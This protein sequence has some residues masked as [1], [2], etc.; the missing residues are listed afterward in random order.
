MFVMY[1]AG[2]RKEV[3]LPK[4]IVHGAYSTLNLLNDVQQIL[5]VTGEGYQLGALPLSGTKDI[6]I[7]PDVISVVVRGGMS[8]RGSKSARIENQVLRPASMRKFTWV[9]ITNDTTPRFGQIMVRAT[10]LF[11]NIIIPFVDIVML[12]QCHPQPSPFQCLFEVIPAQHGAPV[13]RW[14]SVALLNPEARNSHIQYSDNGNRILKT[15][16]GLDNFVLPFLVYEWDTVI[17]EDGFAGIQRELIEVDF[18][19]P[20]QFQPLYQGSDVTTTAKP[21]VIKTTDRFMHF[22]KSFTQRHGE[23][24]F[25]LSRVL[26]PLWSHCATNSRLRIA[27]VR[28]DFFISFL[29]Y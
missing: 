22:P 7:E 8:I 24:D 15:K 12:F 11:L 28:F 20:A 3:S 21:S 4:A 9:E 6:Q 17:E 27:E 14:A 18:L 10:H 2:N 29:R 13:V 19:E 25:D 5:S 1:V 26:L 23:V 16:E